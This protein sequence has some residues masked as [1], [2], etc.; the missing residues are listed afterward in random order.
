MKF[1]KIQEHECPD[2][3]ENEAQG[4]KIYFPYLNRASERKRIS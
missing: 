1:C 3:L 2:G 4:M